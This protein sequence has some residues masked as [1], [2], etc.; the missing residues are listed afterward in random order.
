MFRDQQV[1]ETRCW[2]HT[3]LIT[4]PLF[5]E[6]QT[7]NCFRKWEGRRHPAQI[8]D[9]PTNFL[10]IENNANN[11]RSKCFINKGPPAGTWSRAESTRWE[12]GST[13]HGAFSGLVDALN[14]DPGLQLTSIAIKHC[15]TWHRCLNMHKSTPKAKAVKDCKAALAVQRLFLKPASE[16]FYSYT[17][18]THFCILLS[19]L[20]QKKNQLCICLQGRPK[21]YQSVPG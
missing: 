1:C 16:M 20:K 2:S 10:Q 5:R 18:Q 13:C 3:K 7:V 6:I 15:K 11:T 19:S 21:T 4:L 12:R 9:T 8:S 14:R 17:P